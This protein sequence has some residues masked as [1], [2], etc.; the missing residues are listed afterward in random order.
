MFSRDNDEMRHSVH[1]NR[2]GRLHQLTQSV[3][4]VLVQVVLRVMDL[5]RSPNYHVQIREDEISAR[6]AFLLPGITGTPSFKNN[7]PQLSREFQS[8]FLKNISCNF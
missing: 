5:R 1:C 7:F 2:V 6:S 8:I 3:K 4:G